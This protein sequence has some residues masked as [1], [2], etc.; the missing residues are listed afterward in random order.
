[1]RL[2][3]RYLLRELLV[4]LAFC[5]TGF[6]VLWIALGLLEELD[7]LQELQ[8]RTG[9]IVLYYIVKLPELLPMGLPVALLLALLYTLT[10]LTRHNEI[11]AMRAAGVSLWRLAA[12]Y[13]LVGVAASLALF[14]FNELWIADITERAERIKTGRATPNSRLEAHLERNFG[15]NNSRDGRAWQAAVY[16]R[17][18]AE[19]INLQVTWVL[20]DGARR[21]LYADRAIRTNNM[22]LFLQTNV[23][24][25]PDFTETPQ[26]I[27]SELKVS[28]RL[29]VRNFHNQDMPL[30]EILDYLRFHPRP[31]RADRLRIYTNFHVRLA[32]PWVC[33]VVVLIALPFGA[34]SGRRNIFAGVAGSIFICF[35]Y[36]VLQQFSH[37]LGSVGYVTPWVAA[38]LP[39]L[40]FGVAGAWLTARVR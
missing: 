16:D 2:L 9:D 25:M 4:P 26:E 27:N 22:W 34:A 35:G 37:A 21:W 1:M 29:N 3:D 33:F 11:M 19:M 36:L 30:S 13:F 10:N 8:L 18:T 15:F 38:W 32:S 5:L 24:L 14:A 40:V 17:R 12:P 6:I 23:L 7:K 31:P 28:S 39:N 20:N